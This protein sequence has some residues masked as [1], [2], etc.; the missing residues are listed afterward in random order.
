MILIVL[1]GLQIVFCRRGSVWLSG[2]RSIVC[3]LMAACACFLWCKGGSS[4][5]GLTIKYSEPD[6][7][8][9]ELRLVIPENISA[10]QASDLLTTLH[11]VNY[12]SVL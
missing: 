7:E 11:K 1:A 3:F 12:I 5:S 8:R 4:V 10:V 2:C 9:H 6:E